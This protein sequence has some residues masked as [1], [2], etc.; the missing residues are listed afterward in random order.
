LPAMALTTDSSVLTAVANDYDFSDVFSR[1]VGALAK[2]GDVLVGI[3]T[4]G[5]SK[6][7]INALKKGREIGTKNISLTGNDGGEMKEVSDVNI[8]SSSDNTPRIQECHMTA[9]HVICEIV[10]KEM[11]R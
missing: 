3:S 1:Q 7:V 5:N 8:N 9:Y 11:F 2:E 6:N 10:E 4:S